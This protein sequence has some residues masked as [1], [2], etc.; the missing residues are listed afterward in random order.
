MRR[1][2][3]FQGFVRARAARCRGPRMALIVFGAT[4]DRMR[5]RR[6][7]GIRGGFSFARILLAGFCTAHDKRRT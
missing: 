2:N 7:W 3:V 6:G 1:W 4:C 5:N